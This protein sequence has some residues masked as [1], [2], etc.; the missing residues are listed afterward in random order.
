MTAATSAICGFFC[1]RFGGDAVG[2]MGAEEDVVG[3]WVGCG[4]GFGGVVQV[5]RG[6]QV[7]P[8]RSSLDRRKLIVT[9]FRSFRPFR[10]LDLH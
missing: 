2:L 1:L 6:D 3:L 8:K 5:V 7:L 4:F 10:S 9:G